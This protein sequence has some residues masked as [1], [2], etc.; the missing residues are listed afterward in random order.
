MWRFCFEKGFFLKYY[1]VIRLD[2]LFGFRLV[3][4]LNIVFCVFDFEIF[5][6]GISFY[7][8]RNFFS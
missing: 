8:V 1:V 2:F 7:E 5:M 6:I 3:F 4:Q